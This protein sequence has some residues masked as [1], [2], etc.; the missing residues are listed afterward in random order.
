MKEDNIM[1]IKKYGLFWKRSDIYWGDGGPGN[2]GRLWG[3]I[4]DAEAGEINICNQMGI[5]ALYNICGNRDIFDT[6]DAGI[7]ATLAG[8]CDPYGKNDEL[9]YCGF[10]GRD[11]TQDRLLFH[12]I[13]Q[14]QQPAEDRYGKWNQFSWFGI[15][16]L[17]DDNIFP[18][19]DLNNPEMR[20]TFLKQI[21]A[22]MIAISRPTNN[23]VTGEFLDAIKHKQA[24][25]PLLN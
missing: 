1:F 20:L 7:G 25:D 8:H 4:G 5:Y 16:N 2:R 10:S 3:S 22:V 12:R 6:R 17:G 18:Q 11:E 13:K 21:E 14:H 9:V 23:K 24:R 19:G 15:G